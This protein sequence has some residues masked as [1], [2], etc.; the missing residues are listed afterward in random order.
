MMVGESGYDRKVLDAYWTRPWIT[1]WL[2]ETG[3]LPAPG[4]WVGWEP[5]CGLG[6]ISNVLLDFGY[7]VLSTDIFDYGWGGMHG[8][9]DFLSVDE[10][11]PD[12]KLI[13]TNPPFE[14]IGVPGFPDV[15]AEAFIRHALK[16]MKP[17]KGHVV[18]LLRHEYECASGRRDLFDR[19]P[20]RAK[21]TLTRRPE[22]TDPSMPPKIDP[23]T[24]KPKKSGPRHNYAWFWWDWNYEGARQ[25]HILPKGKEG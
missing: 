19:P 8:V 17:V 10:V 24:G 18:M 25:L 14:V 3:M 16:L 5:A 15:T 23:K 13:L 7:E 6:H 22:W 4:S 9:Q 20:F 2:M 12:V 1:T 11:A 21:F